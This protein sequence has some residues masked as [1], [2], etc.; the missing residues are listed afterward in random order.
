[1]ANDFNTA[2]ALLKNGQAPGNDE[3]LEE[4]SVG[5]DFMID[6]WREKYLE[7][8]ISQGG[9]KIKFVTGKTGS[10]KTHFLEYFTLQAKKTGFVT[11]GFSAKNIWMHDFKDIYIE[12]LRQ[13]DLMGGLHKCSLAIIK[14]LGYNP[15]DIPEEMTFVDFL[16]SRGELD[17][18]IKKDIR[19]QLQELFLSNPFID[20]N[21]G[22]ACGL[23]TGGILGSPILEAGNRDI[24]L[25]WI[26][27]KRDV[28]LAALRK[29][30]LSPSRIT[31]YNA[32]HMLR[33]LAEVFKMA[34]Y[35]GLV[36]VID[37][38]DILIGSDNFELIR[39]TRLK[40][41]DAY[42]SIR[43]LIDDV[44]TLRNIMFVF[45]FDRKL[46]DDETAGLKSYQ[47]L[48]MR[49]Q[50]EIIG[51]RFNRFTDMVD[52]DKMMEQVY[53]AD[54]LLD[55]SKKLSNVINRTENTVEPIS[56][57]KA[58]EILAKRLHSKIS[59]PKLV[60]KATVQMEVDENV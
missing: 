37:D 4:L 1:M 24:L 26:N 42:E 7:E 9:S 12:I 55:M 17:P 10:G 3:L 45:S 5:I 36:I 48:W 33:S 44:D 25:S 38:L 50:N 20:N 58:D 39:Y 59:V 27:G 19:T 57:G 35:P 32:R 13:S 56:Q 16:S 14:S 15:N 22:I 8:F 46:L 52:L 30:G 18:F 60:N 47:A 49:I 23:L 51:N 21:F 40:R 43:E 41:E 54:T 11:T 53:T 2:V 6:F 34:G 31:K 28:K 29:L